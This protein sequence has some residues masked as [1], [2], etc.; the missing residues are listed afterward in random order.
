MHAI[1]AEPIH[2]LGREVT[3]GASVGVAFAGADDT[4]DVMLHAADSAMYD[5]KRE[6]SPRDAVIV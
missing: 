4:A 6:R 5:V 3:I 1:F 2:T